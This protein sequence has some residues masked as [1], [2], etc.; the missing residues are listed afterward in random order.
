VWGSSCSTPKR[1]D[2]QRQRGDVQQQDVLDLAGQYPGL[3]RRPDAD[4]LVGVDPLVGFP[5]EEFRNL[6]LDRRH[7]GLPTDQDDLVDIRGSQ[8]GIRHCL[9]AGL[10]RAKDEILGELFQ[11]GASELH[12]QMLGAG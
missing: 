12:L 10:E 1:L 4:Y 6:L 7:A 5:G 9:L 8:P 11:L 3:D 2:T